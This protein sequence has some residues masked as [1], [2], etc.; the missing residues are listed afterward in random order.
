MRGGATEAVNPLSSSGSFRLAAWKGCFITWRHPGQLFAN[1]VLKKVDYLTGQFLNHTRREAA[2]IECGHS[3][4]S[5]VGCE[6]AHYLRIAI[7]FFGEEVMVFG[8]H[9]SVPMFCL[10]RNIG[11]AHNG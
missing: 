11:K 1:P 3:V 5:A 7:S 9:S 10:R 4:S 2:D 8:L 6:D